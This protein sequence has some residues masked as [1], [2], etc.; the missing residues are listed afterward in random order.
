MKEFIAFVIVMALCASAI[1]GFGSFVAFDLNPAHWEWPL[2]LI[3]GSLM[4]YLTLK[5]LASLDDIL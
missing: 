4:G 1:Y 2:R 3:A 5:A